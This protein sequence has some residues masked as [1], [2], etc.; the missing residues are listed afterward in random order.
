MKEH[1][2]AASKSVGEILEAVVEDGRESLNRTGT[3]VVK[4]YT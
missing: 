1:G 4:D 3:S 2:V